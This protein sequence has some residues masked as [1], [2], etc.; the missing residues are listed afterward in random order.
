MAEAAVKQVKPDTTAEAER[1]LT[2]YSD[3]GEERRRY[4]HHF[5]FFRAMGAALVGRSDEAVRWL[6]KTAELGYPN[7]IAF[8]NEPRLASLHGN[9]GYEA[10][11][12]ELEVRRARWAAENP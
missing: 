6:R 2:G 9:P 10:L 4:Y 7:A 12:A 3:Q 8:R 11:L 5:T 1:E